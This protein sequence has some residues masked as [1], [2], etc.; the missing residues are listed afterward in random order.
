MGVVGV[1]SWVFQRE[2]RLSNGVGM[3][4]R[5]FGR[6]SM[7]MKE[8]EID[9]GRRERERKRGGRERYDDERESNSRRPSGWEIQSERKAK[10]REAKI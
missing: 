8:T 3:L 10:N 1:C 7:R 6:E 5:I 4:R 2:I 9:V